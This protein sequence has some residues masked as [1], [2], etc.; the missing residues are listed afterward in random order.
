MLDAGILRANTRLRRSDDLARETNFPIIITKKHPVT[1]LI[2]KCYHEMDC[3][4]TGV[5]YTVTHL[6]EKYRVIAVSRK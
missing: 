6:R 2:V 5:N 3:H 4:E 1:Q